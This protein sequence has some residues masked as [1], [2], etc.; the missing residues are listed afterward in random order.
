MKSETFKKQIGEN[1]ADFLDEY[2]KEALE[3]TRDVERGKRLDKML[4]IFIYCPPALGAPAE[5]GCT[6]HILRAASP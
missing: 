2:M 3:Q 6:R 4:E 5:A 1:D